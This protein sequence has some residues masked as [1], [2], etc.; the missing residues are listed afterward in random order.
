PVLRVFALAVVLT[1][2]CS[3]RTSATSGQ[4]AVRDTSLRAEL[5]QRMSADEAV[6]GRLAT[7]QRESEQPDSALI[8]RVG[9][10]DGENTRWL[11]E[12]VARR[13]WPGRSI[14]GTD[15]ADAAFL[16]I[17]HADADTAFQAR[18]LPLLAQAYRAGE[19]SGQQLALLTDRVATARGAPQVYGTQLS[20]VAGRAVLKPMIDSAGVDAR[21]ATVGLPPLREYLRLIDSA[22]TSH[23]R[24]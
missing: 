22:Y 1:G 15:G 4:P 13:G 3:S 9:D 11:A 5:L 23:S 7:A 24:H 14:V 21:R 20:L 8:A 2:A 6:R 18:V 19:A 10:V 16:L 12:T 17:Q